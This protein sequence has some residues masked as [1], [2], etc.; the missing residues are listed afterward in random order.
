MHFLLLGISA[1][2]QIGRRH[3]TLSRAV[4]VEY[5]GGASLIAG[6]NYDSR[7]KEDS[8]WGYRIGIAHTLAKIEEIGVCDGGGDY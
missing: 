1:N 7:F 6:I 3:H 4:Y 8:R 2:A 5:G